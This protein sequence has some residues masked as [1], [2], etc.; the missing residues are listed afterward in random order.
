MEGLRWDGYVGLFAS[1]GEVGECAVGL[2]DLNGGDGS[3]S[4][5]GERD[6]ADAILLSLGL[7]GEGEGAVGGRSQGQVVEFLFEFGVT[8]K[9]AQR[10][11]QVVEL[12]GGNAL[13]LP[14]A[15]GVEP[16]EFAVEDKDLARRGTVVPFHAAGL[17]E[18]QR[19]S[20]GL[21]YS[22]ALIG[23]GKAGLERVQLVVVMVY[24]RSQVV[25]R[26]RMLLSAEAG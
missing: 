11:A 1:E 21:F 19:S 8:E 6:P 14:V 10:R 13:H 9:E 15:L 20:F 22:E 17:D 3:F 24:V 5:H 23:F 26:W 18:K 12:L 25:R 4:G 2:F 16:R 7:A